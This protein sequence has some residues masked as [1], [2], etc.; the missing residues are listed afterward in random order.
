MFF[1]FRVV[2]KLQPEKYVQENGWPD[3]FALLNRLVFIA[4]RIFF[5]LTFGDANTTKVGY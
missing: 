2:T 4:E 1:P 5:I 3:S